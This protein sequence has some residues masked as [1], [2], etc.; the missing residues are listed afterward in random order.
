MTTVAL[1]STLAVHNPD[2]GTSSETSWQKVGAPA[3]KR[4]WTRKKETMLVDMPKTKLDLSLRIFETRKMV[5][6][7]LRRPPMTVHDHRRPV[8]QPRPN[9]RCYQIDT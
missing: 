5:L 7:G 4:I 6:D 1:P 3:D 9:F 8:P 2:E